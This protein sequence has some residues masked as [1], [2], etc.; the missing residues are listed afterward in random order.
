MPWTQAAIGKRSLAYSRKSSPTSPR[1][2]NVPSVLT[3]AIRARA[4]AQ[5]TGIT[6]FEE[7]P[8]GSLECSKSATRRSEYHDKVASTHLLG[9]V[10][11]ER[12]GHVQDAVR[13]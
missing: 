2:R 1:P 3:M 10:Y 6:P 5:L 8:K 11:E 12:L 7:W 9:E 4:L 13:A